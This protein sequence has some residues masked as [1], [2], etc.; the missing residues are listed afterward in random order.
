M[1][2][3]AAASSAGLHTVRESDYEAVEL[4][5]RW[6]KSLLNRLPADRLLCWSRVTFA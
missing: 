5:T 4:L 1:P 3:A 6:M 2:T